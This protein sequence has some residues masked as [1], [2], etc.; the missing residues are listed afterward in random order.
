MELREERE[1]R[2]RERGAKRE[3]EGKDDREG[4]VRGSELTIV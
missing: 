3:G 4:R 2:K 1:E